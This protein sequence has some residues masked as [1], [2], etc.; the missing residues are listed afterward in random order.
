MTVS[1]I[2]NWES[3]PRRKSIAKNIIDQRMESGIW[4]N[5]SGITMKAKPLIKRIFS[6]EF[7]LIKI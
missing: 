4:D 1:T 7:V 3:I 6:K 5:P 2:A